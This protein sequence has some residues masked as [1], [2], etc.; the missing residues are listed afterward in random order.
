LYGNAKEWKMPTTDAG[1]LPN[2]AEVLGPLLQ[3]IPEEQQPL[4]IAIAERRA[5]ERYR[6]WAQEVGTEP[7]MSQLRA[8]AQREED[9]A[10][11]VEALYPDADAIQRGMLAKNPDLEEINRTLFAGRSLAQQFTIQAQGERLGAATWRAFAQQEPNGARAAVLLE[12]AELEEQSAVVL[13]GILAA[14]GN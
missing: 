13:E 12:C 2:V 11:R 5:A 14:T 9:I 1:D 10:R 6:D 8:C 3:R 7:G 4:L